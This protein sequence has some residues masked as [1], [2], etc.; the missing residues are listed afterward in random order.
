VADGVHL[1]ALAYDQLGEKYG[2]AYFEHVVRGRPWRALEPRRV[3]CAGRKVRV[4]FQVPVAPLVW[5]ERMPPGAAHP[6]WV[7][8]RG[9]EVSAGAEPLETLSARIDGDSVELTLGREPSTEVR[10]GYAL[11]AAAVPRPHGARRWGQLR[12]SD[13][14]VG[15]TTGTAAPNFA[16]TFQS[17]ARCEGAASPR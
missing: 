8:G 4:D 15:A 6:A 9:F 3:T 16:V 5:D 12:D 17:T 10:V 7:R 2:Q 11:T 14:F 13:P 1:D